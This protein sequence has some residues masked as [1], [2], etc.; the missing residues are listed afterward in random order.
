MYH[1]DKTGNGVPIF[2][3]GVCFKGTLGRYIGSPHN[4]RLSGNTEILGRDAIGDETRIC[5]NFL[6]PPEITPRTAIRLSSV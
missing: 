2:S 3:R 1:T 5:P 6:P 4:C